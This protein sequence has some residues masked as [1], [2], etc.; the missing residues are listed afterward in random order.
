MLIR[1]ICR[2]VFDNRD[3]VAQLRGKSDC[4]LYACM[5]YEPDNDQLVDA[6]FLEL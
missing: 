2:C 6:M 5:C 3:L 4:C 1:V